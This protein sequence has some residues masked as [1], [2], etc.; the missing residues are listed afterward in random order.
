MFDAR[1]RPL[2]FRPARKQ[3][4]IRKPSE[5]VGGSPEGHNTGMAAHRYVW[6]IRLVALLM[7]LNAPLQAVAS[8]SHDSIAACPSGHSTM[9]DAGSADARFVGMH[10]HQ[11]DARCAHCPSQPTAQSGAS[12]DNQMQHL[13]DSSCNGV[14]G[15]CVHFPVGLNSTSAFVASLVRFFT[16]MTQHQPSDVAPDAALRPPRRIS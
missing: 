13:C 4:I 11:M 16:A 8:S 5:L 7:A 3:N 15:S 6:L 12:S 14:C 9:S 10:G 2:R 1:P